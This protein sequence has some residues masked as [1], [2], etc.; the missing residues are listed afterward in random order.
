MA[1]IRHFSRS[2]PRRAGSRLMPVPFIALAAAA[3]VGVGPTLATEGDPH[4]VTICHATH[5]ETNPYVQ[6][7]VD[8]AA[9]DGE[10]NNDHSHHTGPIWYPGAKADGVDWGDIIPPVEGV[11]PGQNWTE[12]GEELWENDCQIPDEPPEELGQIVIEKETDPSNETESFAFD[13]NETP[14]AL[15]DGESLDDIFPAGAYEVSE[16]LSAAQLTAG[17]SL[18]SISCSDNTAV[19]GEDDNVS[20]SLETGESIVCTFLNVQATAAAVAPT[21][22]AGTC[23]APGAL[24]LTPVTGVVYAVTPTYTA[25]ASGTF[26]VNVSAAPGFTLVGPTSFVVTVD[27]R[28]VCNDGALGGNP[29]RTPAPASVVPNTAMEVPS[30]VPAIA[31]SVILLGSLGSLVVLRLSQRSWRSDE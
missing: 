29:T 9:V 5:S 11:N 22:S 7:T 24:T 16:L 23:A 28:L 14:F 8:H 17:W 20:F 4:K 3:L 18:E 15:H 21:V 12:E 26:T 27:A 6:I 2:V 31:L 1:A 10:K 30:Q 13:I 25:G 19:L